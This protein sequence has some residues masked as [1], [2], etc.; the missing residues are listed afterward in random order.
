M[1]HT[2][3]NPEKTALLVC[4]NPDFAKLTKKGLSSHG[5]SVQIAPTMEDALR[6]LSSD[7]L[8]LDYDI[9]VLDPYIGGRSNGE[10]VAAIRETCTRLPI[11][12]VTDKENV[13]LDEVEQLRM[14][15]FGATTSLS[16]KYHTIGKNVRKAQ[17]T[18]AYLSG[19]IQE[20]ASPIVELTMRKNEERL[21]GAVRKALNLE[22]EEDVKQ[23]NQARNTVQS[24]HNFMGSVT[25]GLGKAIGMALLVGV[26]YVIS[27]WVKATKG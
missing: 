15:V 20:V 11:T 9:I 27:V 3:S 24:F 1:S 25:S 2:H 21:I 6:I 26:G 4:D 8:S 10:A 14:G 12:L 5:Y 16:D 19:M 13:E 23:L 17:L 22:T 18:D 7:I